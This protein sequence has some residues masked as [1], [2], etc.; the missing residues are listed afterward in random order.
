[1]ARRRNLI[2]PGSLSGVLTGVLCGS[3]STGAAGNDSYT[4][5]VAQCPGNSFDALDSERLK[6]GPCT[7][8]DGLCFPFPA[9]N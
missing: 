8:R 3:K 5:H 2:S 7:S 9:K 4:V 1:M 6:T